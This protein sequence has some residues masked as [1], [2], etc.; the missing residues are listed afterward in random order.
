M[1][2]FFRCCCY[3]CLFS[4][5]VDSVLMIHA[6]CSHCFSTCC[7]CYCI[8]F[9]YYRICCEVCCQCHIFC[10][11]KYMWICITDFCSLC[12]CPVYE[13]IS[14]F[15][16]CSYCSGIILLILTLIG[17]CTSHYRVIYL[18]GHNYWLRRCKRFCQ[19]RICP[20]TMIAPVI[21]TFVHNQFQFCCVS[22]I[23][24]TCKSFCCVSSHYITCELQISIH[25]YLKCDTCLRR[26]YLCLTV[27]TVIR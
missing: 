4:I 25:I 9:L 26:I 15:C 21:C 22:Y 23:N 2:S 20:V 8:L 1:M 17:C 18:N 13:M 11:I 12:V 3:C 24:I 16:C 5:F 19:F 10:H 27:Y 6:D 14:F 7:C